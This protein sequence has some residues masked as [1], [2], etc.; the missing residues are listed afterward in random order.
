MRALRV[1]LNAAFT[2]K[3]RRGVH[4]R[5]RRLC[6]ERL[7]DR[8]LLTIWTIDAIP[9]IAGNNNGARGLNAQ[10]HAVGYSDD[11]SGH[12][13]AFLYNGTTTVDLGTI[14]GQTYN[15]EA[16]GLNSLDDVVGDS[17]DGSGNK[18]A[19]LKL[20]GSAG[21]TDLKT[22]Q[23][24]KGSSFA[25]AIND[26]QKV[27]GYSVYAATQTPSPDHGFLYSYPDALPIKDLGTWSGGDVS[28]QAWAIENS[29]QL[30]VVGKSQTFTYTGFEQYPNYHAVL[31]Q[32]LPPTGPANLGTIG[33]G[34]ESHAF[35][36][37]TSGHCCGDSSTDQ[38][39]Q[40]G[41]APPHA[42]LY[43][44]SWNTSMLQID[45]GK[46]WSVQSRAMGI[47]ASDQVVG[48][49]TSS[50]DPQA[51]PQDSFLYDSNGMHKLSDL[52][53]PASGWVGLIAYAINDS[54]WIVG[55]GTLNSH[56]RAFL[57][58]PPTTGPGTGGE[59]KWPP[60]SDGGF[61]PGLAPTA[62]GPSGV[63]TSSSIGAD[64]L[65]T[66]LLEVVAVSAET[67]VATVSLRDA[68]T[69]FAASVR[70][71]PIFHCF[72]LGADGLVGRM[73]QCL[74]R[75][76]TRIG[77]VIGEEALDASHTLDGGARSSLRLLRRRDVS[78]RSTGRC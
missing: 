14:A 56:T 16:L 11:G 22:I 48:T 68:V 23:N 32:N 4:D 30:N 2:G 31:W 52:I 6:L 77:L 3:R 74:D 46:P 75:S 45:A 27:V 51:A 13:H 38:T 18:H 72:R 40:H 42:F 7:E 59:S 47:N 69:G 63:P 76:S 35:G 73:G 24:V 33:S 12:T 65:K 5:D 15:S 78:F 43:N 37:N 19:F 55:E 66:S 20:H 28:S 36:I 50:S 54:E 34:H 67:T 21:L 29:T 53:D 57:M 9:L 39:I 41:N 17:D 62:L 61:L 70:G 1:V 49:W 64:P 26:S 25:T 8:C 10:G 71:G 44:P 60:P 58:K